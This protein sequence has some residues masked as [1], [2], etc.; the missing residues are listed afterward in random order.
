MSGGKCH[1]RKLD[2]EAKKKP[3]R[4]QR[5]NSTSSDF[6]H[7][8]EVV[9]K[10]IGEISSKSCTDDCAVS[11]VTHWHKQQDC[12]DCTCSIRRDVKRGAEI[13]HLH[14][15]ILLIILMEQGKNKRRRRRTGRRRRTRDKGHFVPREW[16][17]HCMNP[18]DLCG[19]GGGGVSEAAR[20]RSGRGRLA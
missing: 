8:A 5:N 17:V 6:T 9:L 3:S 10:F 20:A 12:V 11:C 7:S 1:Q 16:N 13:K 15:V 19:V 4:N 18:C 14:A 2:L